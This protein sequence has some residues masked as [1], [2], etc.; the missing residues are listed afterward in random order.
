M[1]EKKYVRDDLFTFT[2]HFTCLL[3]T[4]QDQ[5]GTSYLGRMLTKEWVGE[6]YSLLSRLRGIAAFIFCSRISG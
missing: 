1:K 5:P 6:G 4:H 3:F 2:L